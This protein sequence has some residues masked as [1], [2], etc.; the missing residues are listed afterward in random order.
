MS[1][2]NLFSFT[3]FTILIIFGLNSLA[4]KFYWYSSIWYF[5]I[6]MH[7]LGGFWLGLL[8]F[9]FVYSKILPNFDKKYLVNILIGVF[10]VGFIWE[11]Y[12]ILVN[13]VFAKNAFD[14]QDTIEDLIADMTGGLTSYYLL[15]YII[16]NN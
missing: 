1:R 5:D 10:L 9:Y 4:T 16:K 6:I 12:E 2:N 7:F 13:M 15:K 3:A 11:L 14:L 8:F